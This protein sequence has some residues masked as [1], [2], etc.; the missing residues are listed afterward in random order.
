MKWYVIAIMVCL[1]GSGSSTAQNQPTVLPDAPEPQGRHQSQESGA[2][3]T[4]PATPVIAQQFVA[5]KLQTG[6]IVG[7]VTDT[8]NNAVPGASIV[9]EGPVPG[10]RRTVVTDDNGFFQLNDL[11]PGT[12]Y[13]VTI[14]AKDLQSGYPPSSSSTQDSI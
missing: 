2:A 6:T 12:P 10:D 13:R 8:N 1:C 9:L 14:S 3:P 4:I 5:P 11:E 7:N